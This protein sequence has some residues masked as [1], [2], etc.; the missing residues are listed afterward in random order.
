MSHPRSIPNPRT[1]EGAL[2]RAPHAAAVPR[3]GVARPARRSRRASL[4]LRL[5]RAL[6]PVATLYVGKL[7][8]DDVVQLVQMPNRPATLRG[9]AGERPAE[10]A[11]RAAAGRVRAG[12][13]CPTC[14][15]GRSSLVDEPARR[16]G[17][18]R[19]ERAADGACRHARPRGFR[20]CRVPGPARAGAAPDQ[21]PAHPDGPAVRPGAGRRHRREPRRRPAGLRA[22]A[23]PA[24]GCSR[25]C[26][27]SWARR[28]STPGPTRSISAAR[29]SGASSTMCARR[30]PAS[31][32]PRK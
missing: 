32:P 24:A 2:R 10:R 14:W 8:I 4:L 15:A 19:L 17:H 26:R 28:I 23:D 12:R 25:W 3:H 6:L 9:L 30:R 1:L 18:Q 29:R 22:V 5:V 13:R 21:R 7:I 31:R 11:G 20:G 27:P 16:A